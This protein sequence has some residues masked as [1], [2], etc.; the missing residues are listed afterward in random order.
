LRGSNFMPSGS[1]FKV[2]HAL[3]VPL[4]LSGFQGPSVSLHHLFRSRR[5]LT[6]CYVGGQ[7]TLILFRRIFTW[8]GLAS[9]FSPSIV[10]QDVLK[11]NTMY[12]VDLLRWGWAFLPPSNVQLLPGILLG[13][14][15]SRYRERTVR[16]FHWVHDKYS[17]ITRN[18]YTSLS[19]GFKWN[20][21]DSA[22]FIF[23]AKWHVHQ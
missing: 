19:K 13:Q 15:S 1:V 9:N 6:S 11:T 21:V 18:S 23:S 10:Y 2:R 14:K 20:P 17:N 8:I 22:V 3:E 5:T 7:N 4:S 16:Q 12:D